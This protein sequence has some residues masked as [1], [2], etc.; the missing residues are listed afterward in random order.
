MPSDKASCLCIGN[1]LIGSI[2]LYAIGIRVLSKLGDRGMLRIRT[3]CQQYI[4]VHSTLRH[5]FVP[6]KT[7]NIK[8]STV[9]AFLPASRLCMLKHLEFVQTAADFRPRGLLGAEFTNTTP[10]TLTPS[11]LCTLLDVIVVLAS[12]MLWV[13]PHICFHLWL[14]RRKRSAVILNYGYESTHHLRLLRHFCWR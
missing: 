3:L 11:P 12:N 8:H 10:S 1:P 9:A 4:L 5:P 14:I 6:W 7:S 13:L 2:L